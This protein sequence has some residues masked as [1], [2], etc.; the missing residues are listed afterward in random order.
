MTTGAVI[1]WFLMATTGPR[2]DEG[3]PIAH[4]HSLAHFHTKTE[5]EKNALKVVKENTLPGQV[6]TYSCVKSSDQDPDVPE[7]YGNDETSK[8]YHVPV[9]L[10]EVYVVLIGRAHEPDGL[11]W[12]PQSVWSTKG[13][14]QIE[15]EKKLTAPPYHS[16]RSTSTSAPAKLGGMPSRP[17]WI[18]TS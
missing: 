14:C 5:C 1:L 13:Q 11:Y 3:G 8:V 6:T 15:A 2:M 16:T 4:P 17:R 7:S 18:R 12:E 10:P 9:P